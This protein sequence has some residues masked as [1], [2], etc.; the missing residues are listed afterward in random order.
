MIPDFIMKIFLKLINYVF[1]KN[2]IYIS[3]GF[4]IVT[5]VIILRV[6]Y[7]RTPRELYTAI[8]WEL[9]I[10]YIIIILNFLFILILCIYNLL[11]DYEKININQNTK[12]KLF[13]YNN[14]LYKK[15]QLF[16]NY[17]H[18]SLISFD[19][20]IKHNIIKK[21]ALIGL[22]IMRKIR[23]KVEYNQLVIFNWIFDFIPKIGVA[24]TF[25]ID[26]IFYNK[27][28]FFYKSVLFI[29]IPIIY[30]YILY[31]IK[32]I[33]EINIK[34]AINEFII[35]DIEKNQYITFI[36]YFNYIAKK[37]LSNTDEMSRYFT[38]N[39]LLNKNLRLFQ[40]NWTEQYLKIN[41]EY[42]KPLS[43]DEVGNILLTSYLG[44]HQ[45][46]ILMYIYMIRI[47][48]H[49]E[50]TQNWIRLYMST[51]FFIGWFYLL[52]YGLNFI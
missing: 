1:N 2:M 25:F 48:A 13:I 20:F 32:Q 10:I 41:Q 52:L 30:S 40:F 8:S 23:D 49:K 46:F 3:L 7:P 35:L 42:L 39:F 17:Y 50:M 4:I 16:Y 43:D 5:F 19:I 28:Y 47:E 14:W 12:M 33:C 31:T 51:I 45:V 18:K 22:Y 37:S 27:F 21:W 24:T 29:I 9:S 34:D 26:V 6:F 36:E 15:L 38:N 44:L 11:K